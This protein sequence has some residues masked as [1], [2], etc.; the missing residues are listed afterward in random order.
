MVSAAFGLA[1]RLVARGDRTGAIS[2]LDQVPLTSRHYGEAQ[3][4]SAL[5]LVGGRPIGE[6]TEA[7][8]RDAARRV[9][10]LADT[11]P[12][13]LQVRALV[14]GTALDWLRAGATPAGDTI[15]DHSFDERV[16]ARVPK[17]RSGS[18]RGIA[19][20]A[21]PLHPGRPGEFDQATELDVRRL[22]AVGSQHDRDVRTVD[23]QR[24]PTPR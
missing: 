20:A 7:D 16:C 18:W 14:L 2:V 11:E 24:W 4:T 23:M 13:L 19:A 8:L 21:P 15:C 12:R 17:R 6:I 9:G 3:L 10:L 5:I 1:R 22:V